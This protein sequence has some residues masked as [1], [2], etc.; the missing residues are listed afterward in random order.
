[1]QVSCVPSGEKEN[2]AKR[3][4]LCIF[5]VLFLHSP[6]DSPL[7]LKYLYLAEMFRQNKQ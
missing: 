2:K 1:M 7:S 6:S 3:H 5:A 4:R